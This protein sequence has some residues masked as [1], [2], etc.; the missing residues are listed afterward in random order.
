VKLKIQGVSPV[1]NKSRQSVTQPA[2][3]DADTWYPVAAVPPSADTRQNETSRWRYF[4][5]VT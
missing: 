4:S 1:D 5:S 3:A 2:R